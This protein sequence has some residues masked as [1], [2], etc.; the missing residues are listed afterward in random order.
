MTFRTVP[1]VDITPEL[2]AAIAERL[3][4]PTTVDRIGDVLRVPRR[5]IHQ[6]G[7]DM[8]LELAQ[9]SGAGYMR[10]PGQRLASDGRKR[11]IAEP[12]LAQRLAWMS[13]PG[14]HCK[15]KETIIFFP[16]SGAHADEA[17]AICRGCPVRAE[18]EDHAT[19]F[20]LPGIW[21]GTSNEERKQT[22][23]GRRTPRQLAA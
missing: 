21:G 8:G 2:R 11:S 19:R 14:R 3:L 22:R 13:H 12:P 5:Q 6:V 18:C 10:R 23:T 15:G 17:K 20:V 1:D 4:R 16:E 9:R 7:Y